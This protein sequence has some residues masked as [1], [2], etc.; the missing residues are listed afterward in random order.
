MN[1]IKCAHACVRVCV[2]SCKD[3]KEADVKLHLRQWDAAWVCLNVVMQGS[4]RLVIMSD[5]DGV[6]KIFCSPSFCSR[7]A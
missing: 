2:C 5:Y 3:C 4:E 7:I 6:F 1:K